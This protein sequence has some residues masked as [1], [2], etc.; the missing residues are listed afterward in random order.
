MIRFILV[1]LCLCL[2]QAY[3]MEDSLQKKSEQE[4]KHLDTMVACLNIIKTIN[5]KDEK[6]S[7]LE[8]LSQEDK[9]FINTLDSFKQHSFSDNTIVP[10]FLKKGF[11]I[12]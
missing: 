8:S 2:G 5:I 1:I 3:G 10:H 11:Y 9:L 4:S 12:F 7:L 6:P